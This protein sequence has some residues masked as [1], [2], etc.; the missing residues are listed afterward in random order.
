MFWDSGTRIA[1]CSPSTLYRPGRGKGE[2]MKMEKALK[3]SNEIVSGKAYVRPHYGINRSKDKA[4][5]LYGCDI[6]E[7]KQIASQI[8][9]KINGTSRVAPGFAAVWF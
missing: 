4:I 2:K 7:A 9:S 5:R 3:L 6:N 1:I 8:A